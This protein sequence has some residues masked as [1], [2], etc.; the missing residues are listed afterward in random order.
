MKKYDEGYALVFVLVVM[1]VMSLV[2]ASVL[3]FSLRNMQSQQA[4]IERMEDK[5]T[6]QGE[7]EK[8]IDSLI[9]GTEVW[10]GEGVMPVLEDDK[11]TLLVTLTKTHNTATVTC[12]VKI[13][14]ED[15]DFEVIT[16]ND[17]TYYKATGVT[18]EY[19][20]YEVTYSTGGDTE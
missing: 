3:T 18:W 14:S 5:Y 2:S 11:R 4:S 19:A 17:V 1:I 9:H 10:S 12:V 8:L 6:A 13:K 7:V 20:S 16:E 15:S